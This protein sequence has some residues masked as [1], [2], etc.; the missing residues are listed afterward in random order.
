MKPKHTSLYRSTRVRLDF[1]ELP[2]DELG[3]Y[4]A[5]A[6]HVAASVLRDAGHDPDTLFDVVADSRS[7]RL[8]FVEV[9]RAELAP[10][11]ARALKILWHAWTLRQQ[12]ADG[13]PGG[14]ALEAIRLAQ[15]AERFNVDRAFLKPVSARRTSDS[16]LKNKPTVADEKILAVI[17]DARF[18]GRK[19]Q[20]HKLGISIRQL[21]HRLKKLKTK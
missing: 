16:N 1:D 8:R 17:N 13:A 5:N 2:R 6:E 7:G 14:V 11:A 18:R 20:A 12:L 4:I 9:E 15:H 10:D 19:Q 21:Q 3:D